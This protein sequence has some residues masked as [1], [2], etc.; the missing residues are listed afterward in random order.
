LA[1]AVELLEKATVEEPQNFDVWLK[2]AEVYG[3]NCRDLNRAARIVQKMEF[4]ATFTP[5][6]MEF[7]KAKLREWRAGRRS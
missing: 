5:Q 6:E 1:T 7:A 2:L 3:V 4:S